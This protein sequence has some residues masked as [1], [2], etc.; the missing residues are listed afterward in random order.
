VKANRG[1]AGVDDQ[2]IEESER[3]LENNLYKPWNRMSSGS[4]FPPP[5]IA[6]KSI[7][8]EEVQIVRSDSS[9]PEKPCVQKN[10]P[11]NEQCRRDHQSEQSCF[12]GPAKK[13]AVPPRRGKYRHKQTGC[14]YDKAD[15]SHLCGDW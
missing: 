5:V 3:E 12:R 14:A 13:E 10:W 9:G 4:Y 8:F 11:Q 6:E 1:A 15:S 2:M 7:V